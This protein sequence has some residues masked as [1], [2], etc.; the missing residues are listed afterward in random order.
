MN[1]HKGTKNLVGQVFGQ[2]KVV[3]Y[4]GI[5]KTSKATYVVWTCKCSCGNKV[6]RV[7]IALRKTQKKGDESC[8]SHSCKNRSMVVNIKVYIK[9]SDRVSASTLKDSHS[10][11]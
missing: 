4:A 11:K 8:C 2:L 7:G 10:L 9:V 3:K 1:I 5:R 6:E